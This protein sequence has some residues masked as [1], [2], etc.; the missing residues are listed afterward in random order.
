MFAL[1]FSF[2]QQRLLCLGS[3]LTPANGPLELP[4][5]PHAGC[6]LSSAPSKPELATC[7]CAPFLSGHPALPG[8]RLRA[9]MDATKGGLSAA[10]ASG[11]ADAD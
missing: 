10:P 5:G 2:F 11:A 3:S 4:E 6:S 7:S 8:D 1:T 9:R